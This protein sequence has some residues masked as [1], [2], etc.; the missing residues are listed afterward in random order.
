MLETLSL[1]KRGAMASSHADAEPDASV[2]CGC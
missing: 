1:A 2:E